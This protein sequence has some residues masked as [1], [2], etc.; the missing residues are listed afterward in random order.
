MPLFTIPSVRFGAGFLSR[1]FSRFV[2]DLV[3]IA[4]IICDNKATKV[5]I[6]FFSNFFSNPKIL[7]D[8][9]IQFG[10]RF[11]HLNIQWNL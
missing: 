10:C 1:T 6:Y 3:D 7:S 4:V 5:Y 9:V 2:K 8:F 11:L